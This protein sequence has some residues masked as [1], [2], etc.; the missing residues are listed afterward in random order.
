MTAKLETPRL[1]MKSKPADNI[2]FTPLGLDKQ[3]STVTNTI[4]HQLFG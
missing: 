2:A 1:R 4:V 3:T